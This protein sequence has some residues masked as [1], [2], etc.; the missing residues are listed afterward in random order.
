MFVLLAGVILPPLLAPTAEAFGE[1]PYEW[2]QVINGT[3]HLD[4]YSGESVAQ[5]FV[6]TE[7]Y[8]LWN[9]TLRLRNTGDTTDAI[10][11]TIR[12]DS[13]GAPAAA[14]LAASNLVIGNTVLGQ[15]TLAFSAPP[16]LTKGARY[17]IVAT[18]PSILANTHEWHHS[19]ANV[20][21]DGKA[22]INLSL[23]AGWRTDGKW[24]RI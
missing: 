11:V 12:S 21:A 16:V 8:E 6:A 5:S 15:Y 2:N 3:N 7:S 23:G 20:Y 17:W 4:V 10:N 24:R 18:C 9:V 14:Y 22:L 1:R 13:A 19:A